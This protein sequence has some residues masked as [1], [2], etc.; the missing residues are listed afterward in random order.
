MPYYFDLNPKQEKQINNKS[1]LRHDGVL[2]RNLKP[3]KYL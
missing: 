2:K 1:K 3:K